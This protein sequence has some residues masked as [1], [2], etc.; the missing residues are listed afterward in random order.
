MQTRIAWWHKMLGKD[1]GEEA[2][3]K[4]AQMRKQEEKRLNEEPSRCLDLD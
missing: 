3:T 1:R 4:P 2:P